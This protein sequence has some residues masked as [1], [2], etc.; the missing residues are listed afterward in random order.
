MCDYESIESVNDVLYDELHELVQTP[1]F[2]YFRVRSS[3]STLKIATL[4]YRFVGGY[5]PT[6]IVNVR[7]GK[8]TRYA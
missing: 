8:R 1:F 3:D 2:K 6:F 7:S 4:I 5:R